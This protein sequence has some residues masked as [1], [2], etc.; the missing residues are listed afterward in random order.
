MQDLV[1]WAV[2][3][4]I[5]GGRI[6][7]VI[8]DHGL[9]FGAGKH[10]IQALYVW[11]GGLGVWGAIAL[12]AVG[13]ALGARRMKI[14]VRPLLDVIAPTVLLAQGIGRWGNWFNQELFGRPTNLP[15]GLK[16]DAS[17]W[18]NGYTPPA[19]F[20]HS[21]GTYATFHP[22]F[23]YESVW[24]ISMFFLV[25]W[26]ERKFKLGAGRVAAAYVMAYCVGRFWVEQL[27][28]DTIEL[29]DVLGM[30]WGDWMAVLLFVGAAA[31]FIWAT[32]THK[33]DDQGLYRDQPDEEPSLQSQQ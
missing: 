31:Y 22:T 12:G 3:F 14:R 10:P 1:L 19:Q 9:Y 26:V 21:N 29:N 18:P 5:V 30:R 7:H 20:Q 6:Y 23:L 32:V 33:V 2:P 4:G 13:L 27:R 24:D 25:I 8:T 11:N 28:I 15:W 16:I 17:H